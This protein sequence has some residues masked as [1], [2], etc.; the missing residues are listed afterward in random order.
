LQIT[1]ASILVEPSK[2]KIGEG[3]VLRYEL[4]IP[5]GE[6]AHIRIEYG[7]DF[8]KARGNISRKLFLLSDKTVTGGTH[9][10]GTKRHSFA[11]LTIRRHY[12]G[13][14]RINLL[15]N[16]QVKAHTILEITED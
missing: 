8:V 16:G 12:P 6:S 10:S 9:I 5:K 1:E 2:I 13:E 14:H 3:C 7:I 15:I 11:D 4:D